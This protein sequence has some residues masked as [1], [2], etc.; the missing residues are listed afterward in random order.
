VYLL[1]SKRKRISWG[2]FGSEHDTYTNS[3]AILF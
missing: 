2:I 1:I 3:Y